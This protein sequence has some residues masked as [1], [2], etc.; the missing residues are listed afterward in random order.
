[1]Q[2]FFLFVMDAESYMKKAAQNLQALGLSYL[3]QILSPN[4]YRR[5]RIIC[6]NL[7]YLIALPASS[8][9]TSDG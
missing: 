8:F 2:M 3:P 1:M 4:I 5:F 7:N 9:S 6:S